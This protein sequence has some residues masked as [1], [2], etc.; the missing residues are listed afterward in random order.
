VTG[1]KS[2]IAV[3][4]LTNSK[5][6]ACTAKAKNTVGTGPDSAPSSDFIAASAPAAPAVSSV[7]RSSGA[8][9]IAFTTP[10]ANG[11]SILSYKVTCSSANGGTARTVSGGSSPILVTLLT[12]TKTY[13]CNVAAVNAIGTGAASP[14]SSGFVAA[15]VPVAP[16]ISTLTRSTNAVSVAFLPPVNNGAAITGYTTTCTSSNGGAPGTTSGATSPL[17]VSSLTNSKNYTCIVK[18]TNAMGDSA[19][20]AGIAFVA[21]A[22]PDTPTITSIAAVRGTATIVFAVPNS[23]GAAITAYTATCTSSNGGTTRTGTYNRSPLSVTSLTIGK[24]YTCVL[25]ATN[26]LGTSAPTVPSATFVA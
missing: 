25:T 15:A 20:S 21:A 17:V 3:A 7:T 14:A 8:A 26:A 22:A 11:A 12:A 23:N 5:T 24:T 19:W 6:Y 2:P 9:T 18:A 10:A 13:T 16:K 4:S 1:I